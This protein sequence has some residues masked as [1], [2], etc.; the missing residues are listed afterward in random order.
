M[1]ESLFNSFKK[2]YNNNIN[3]ILIFNFVILFIYL[4]KNRK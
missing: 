4:F 1:K 3:N 2:S